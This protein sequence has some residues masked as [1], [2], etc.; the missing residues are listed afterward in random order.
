MRADH[1]VCVVIPAL[2]EE[3]SIGRVIADIPGWVD[4]IVVGDNGS[5]DHTAQVAEQCGALVVHEPRRGYG[6]ACLM[7]IGHL[8][9]PGVVVFLDGDYSDYP[10]EMG[11]LVDP[12]ARGEADLVIGSR[13]RGNPLP[14]ALTSQQRAGNWLAC[15]LIRLFWGV[16]FSD[17][18]PFRAISWP[19]YQ[20][21]CMRDPDYGWTVEMQVKAAIHGL[22]CLE[23]PVSY[24]RRIGVSKVSGTV[25]GVVRAGY[26]ILLTI[27]RAAWQ[28]KGN[29]SAARGRVS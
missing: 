12:V 25:H 16:R 29:S 4:Q 13:V 18:G 9:D 6:S 1:R 8:K 20:K 14:G 23:V 21:L 11:R 5:R 3:S 24:R 28:G 17:L 27:F 26:K 15:Q 22:R 2:D 10:A 19:A 7:A